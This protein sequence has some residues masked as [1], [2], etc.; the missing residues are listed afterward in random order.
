MP[1][2]TPSTN[3]I[4]PS[5]TNPVVIQSAPIN[6]IVRFYNMQNLTVITPAKNDFQGKEQSYTRDSSTLPLSPL[7]TPVMQNIT[8]KSVTY[9]DFI[10]KIKRTTRDLTLINILLNVSQ[11]KK[12]ITTEIQGRDGTVKEYIGMD[13][14]AVTINGMALGD[15]GNHPADQIIELR[16][17]LIARVPIPVVCTY[18][19]N[20]GIFSLVIKDFTLD[21]EAGGYSKQAFT[22][23]SMSDVD[24]IL[25]I[26]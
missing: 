6:E 10:S 19:N 20:L 3:N 9:T 14:Y 4:L 21:Q 11:A 1:D 23:N 15:N 22:I 7:G 16:S 5:Q 17:H 24:V 25:Q 2:I 18:L 12:I 26:L 8:F 13:D